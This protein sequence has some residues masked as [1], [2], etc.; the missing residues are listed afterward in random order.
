MSLL[1]LFA[2]EK[3]ARF[4]QELRKTILGKSGKVI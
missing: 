2:C 3:L 4:W 1:S